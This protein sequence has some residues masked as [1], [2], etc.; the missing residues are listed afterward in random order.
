MFSAEFS[1]QEKKTAL[2]MNLKLFFKTCLQHARC[3][4][5]K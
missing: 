2:F 5:D 1:R 3:P 4:Q